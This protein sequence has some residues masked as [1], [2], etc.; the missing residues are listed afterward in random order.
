MDG[1]AYGWGIAEYST[2]EKF[3]GDDFTDRVFYERTPE[4]SYQ[5][6]LVHLKELLP[7]ADEGN[8]RKILK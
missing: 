8:I 4:Q 7:D 1:K 5:R 6:I 2:P 3:I